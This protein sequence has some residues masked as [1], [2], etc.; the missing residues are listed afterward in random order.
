[1]VSSV[2]FGNGD[3][4]LYCMRPYQTFFVYL[5]SFVA[6]R[7]AVPKFLADSTYETE[8]ENSGKRRRIRPSRLDSTSS[9]EDLPVVKRSKKAV[10]APPAIPSTSKSHV[11]TA[12]KGQGPSKEELRKQER[13]ELMERLKAAR[14]AAAAKMG[15]SGSPWKITVSFS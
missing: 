8:M 3:L 1:M 7:S 4:D 15:S 5:D 10:P 14:A 13:K 6:A 2:S 12:R 9:D 11:K